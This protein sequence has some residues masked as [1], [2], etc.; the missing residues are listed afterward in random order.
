M[1]TLVTGPTG[2]VGTGLI[3]HLLADPAR[4]VVAACRGIPGHL[5]ASADRVELLQVGDLTAHTDWR[6][7]LV[8]VDT[9]VHLAARVHVMHDTV[10]EPLAA[11][12]RVNVD[13]SLRL[14]AQAD[15]RRAPFCLRQLDQGERRSHHF[16]PT[17]SGR[18]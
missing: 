14:G 15:S 1:R 18:R 11:F 12:R 16:R 2:F 17:V 13:G 9:V 7:A 10:D 5:D 8:G 4:L 3:R 6:K